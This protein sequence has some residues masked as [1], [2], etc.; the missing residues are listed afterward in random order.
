M[1]GDKITLHQYAIM[2]RTETNFTIDPRTSAI[3]YF[4]L[5]F[6]YFFPSTLLL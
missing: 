2:E 4:P 1:S 6:S 5:P 3:H